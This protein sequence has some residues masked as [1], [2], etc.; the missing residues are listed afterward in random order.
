MVQ[1]YHTFQIQSTLSQII[2][3]DHGPCFYSKLI[4][5]HNHGTYLF[6]IVICTAPCNRG[7]EIIVEFVVTHVNNHIML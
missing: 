6:R 1:E 5:I 4:T 7:S 2:F 3:Q